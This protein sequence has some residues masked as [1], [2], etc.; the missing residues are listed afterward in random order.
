[1][2]LVLLPLTVPVMIFGSG[3]LFAVM[4]GFSAQGYLALLAAISL[5]ATAFYRLRLLELFALALLINAW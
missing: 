1:M 3:S 4:Q 2:A 5:L